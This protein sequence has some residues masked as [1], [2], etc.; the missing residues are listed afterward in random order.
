MNCVNHFCINA[1][2]LL[3]KVQHFY[4]LYNWSQSK[5]QTQLGKKNKLNNSYFLLLLIKFF[6]NH[7]KS[8]KWNLLFYHV[9]FWFK[10]CLILE[11]LIKLHIEIIY[12]IWNKKKRLKRKFVTV[13]LCLISPATD[14]RWNSVIPLLLSVSA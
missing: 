3:S 10:F 8:S 7:L 14:H 11:E 6:V 5:K 1:K 2:V 12:K 4:S 9:T 13:L